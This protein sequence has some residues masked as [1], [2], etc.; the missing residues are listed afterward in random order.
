[1]RRYQEG[2]AVVL[3]ALE[4]ATDAELDARPGQGDW[5]AREVVHH[6]SDSEMTSALRLRK[7]LAE[8][9]AEIQGYDEPLY[10]RRFRYAERPIE[11]ALDAFGA[12]RR[13]TAELFPMLTDADWRRHGKHSESGT[14]SAEDWLEIYAAHAHEHAAQIERCLHLARAR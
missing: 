1:M 12:A 6:L 2:H 7:L 10:A 14:Y 5:T 11:A 3:R 13:V 8:D 4:G 9:D